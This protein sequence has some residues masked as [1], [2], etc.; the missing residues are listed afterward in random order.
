MTELTFENYLKSNSS[1]DRIAIV[2][3]AF[4]MIDKQNEYI[5]LLGQELNETS[6]IAAIHG[7][8]SDKIEQGEDLRNEMYAI[9][10]NN[11]LK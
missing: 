2:E 7:W 4:K 8:R 5:T 9:I 10:N 3:R 11:K 6:I 1:E